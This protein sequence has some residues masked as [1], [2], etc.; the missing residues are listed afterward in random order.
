[1]LKVDLPKKRG[2]QVVN[3]R[4][5][6]GKLLEGAY[7]LSSAIVGYCQSW[8]LNGAYWEQAGTVGIYWLLAA[9]AAACFFSPR[10]SA[11]SHHKFAFLSSCSYIV[12]FLIIVPLAQTQLFESCQGFLLCWISMIYFPLFGTINLMLLIQ[13]IRANR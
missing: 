1:M 3:A 5:T 2:M 4:K 13:Y 7:F 8:P 10:K 9:G 12:Y 11:E 6:L